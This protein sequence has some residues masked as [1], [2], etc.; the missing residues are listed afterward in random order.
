MKKFFHILA[1]L[2]V[3]VLFSACNDYET[4][5]DQK[6]KERNAVRRFIEQEGINE[7]SESVFKQNGNVTDTA[8]NEYVYLNNSG[9]Y[10]QIV[11]KGSGQPL[12]NGENTSLYIRF[13]EMSIF[14]TAYVITNYEDP[15]DPDVMSISRS[16]NNFTASF[17]SGLMLEYYS[18]QVPAGWLAP[19][20]YINVG[21]PT[22]TEDIAKV[23][24][25]VPHTQGHT[26]AASDV[27]PFFYE[28]SFQR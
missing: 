9:V 20:S 17:T 16:G 3:L 22:A 10:M 27:V 24:L 4:Y 18:A 8:K 11:R 23:R 21:P 5:S 26:A 1:P 25:I 13:R 6:E 14:D 19:F 7:I 2:I 28:I 12:Q 15:Y